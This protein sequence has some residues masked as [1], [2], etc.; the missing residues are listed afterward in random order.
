MRGRPGG[1][2]FRLIL[3][4]QRRAHMVPAPVRRRISGM[5]RRVG[6]RGARPAGSVPSEDWFF[7]LVPGRT[8]EDIQALPTTT[9]LPDRSPAAPT[10][11][12]EPTALRCV[13][14]TGVLDV[15]GAEEFAAF[16]SRR[17]PRH[18]FET[19]VVYSG[20]KLSGQ[21][22][23]GGRLADEL[24]REGVPTK[25]LTPELSI[26]W[27]RQHRP[28]VISAHYAPDWLLD[29]ANTLDVPWVETLHG[30]HSFFHPDSWEPE[31]RRARRLSAQIAVSDLVRRQY[32]ARNPGF[33]ADRI[34]TIPNGVNP[35]RVVK[36]D[37]ERARAALGLADEFL[38]VSLAR[39]CLQKNTYGLVAAFADVARVHPEA[40]LLVAGRADDPLYFTQTR[41]LA[42]TLPAA[43]RVHLR[44]HCTNPAALLAAA[45]AFVLDSF[46]EGWSLASM[47]AI[48]AGTPVVL[49]DVG[50]AREQLTGG[51]PRGYLVGNPGGA[52]E[53]VEWRRISDL[54]FRQQEN[55]AEF[56]D[57]T[58]SMVRD[59]E[60]WATARERL[61]R[62]AVERFSADLCLERHARVLRAV[63]L[64][65]SLPETGPAHTLSG[66]DA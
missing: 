21:P 41:Q 38:F 33:A 63:A 53:L 9:A 25:Q 59:R 35:E 15:G 39:Y 31:R 48:A 64:G 7:P 22:G 46:F 1:P 49:S 62:E 58:S 23:E 43:D 42:E 55:R 16:L 3:W 66:S 56:V 8:G 29:A 14:A 52:P 37:R 12:A 13:I 5:L 32:L 6:M 4:T 10:A 60:R 28:D 47:E 50:G 34:V 57:A 26:E 45:D 24:A 40:H 17:L 51:E 61:R 2:L 54:R 20:R 65:E 27:L 36:V 30:M 11:V 18:G 44:G 19:I